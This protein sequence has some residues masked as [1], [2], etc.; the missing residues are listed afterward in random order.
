[1]RRIE[2]HLKDFVF[3]SESL[4]GIQRK[5]ETQKRKEKKWEELKST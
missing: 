4:K 3:H 5:F 1:M 2:I